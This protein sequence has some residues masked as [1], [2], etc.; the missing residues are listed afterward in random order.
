MKKESIWKFGPT[1]R[2][3]YSTL[4]Q[5]LRYVEDCPDEY[6]ND[7][8]LRVALIRKQDWD[9]ADFDDCFARMTTEEFAK[10]RPSDPIEPYTSYEDTAF[11]DSDPPSNVFDFEE[12]A[13]RIVA[14]FRDLQRRKVSCDGCGIDWP[15][16]SSVW[17]PRDLHRYEYIHNGYRVLPSVPYTLVKAYYCGDKPHQVYYAWHGDEG[18]EGVISRSEIEILIKCMKVAIA[19]PE[20]CVHNVP[21][22]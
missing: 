10:L 16:S 20:F 12:C 5:I 8:F 18:R 4:S 1:A 17:I 13:L 22:S 21:V 14:F 3:I 11:P 19:D 15:E 7:E 9:L 2:G 6:L